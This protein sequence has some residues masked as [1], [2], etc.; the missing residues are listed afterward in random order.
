MKSY[1]HEK[2]AA[3]VIELPTRE[4]E[5]KATYELPIIGKGK[6]IPNSFQVRFDGSLAL[7][8][9]KAPKDAANLLVVGDLTT[10]QKAVSLNG[11]VKFSH[12]QLQKDLTIRTKGSAGFEK[13]LLDASVELDIFNKKNQK[14]VAAVRVDHDRTATG[15]NVTGKIDFTSKGLVLDI[16]SSG[17]VYS[18]KD[19][20]SVGAFAYYADNKNVK[21][22]WGGFVEGSRTRLFG[23]VSIFCFNF[24]G[25]LVKF[26][27]I[28]LRMF[29]FI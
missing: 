4:I 7:D 9:K 2:D 25:R 27:I 10:A 28:P 20:F 26:L 17:H 6:G 24:W 14:I 13:R 18:A 15:H 11:E 5:A 23:V 1:L 19:G 8:K 21:K 3:V 12:P 29:F 22:E 16:G